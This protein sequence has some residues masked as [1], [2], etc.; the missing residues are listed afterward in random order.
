MSKTKTISPP[1]DLV[2]QE[3]ASLTKEVVDMKAKKVKQQDRQAQLALNQPVPVEELGKSD[4][5]QC[6][7]CGL[8]FKAAIVV[9]EGREVFG[10]K[11]CEI[12]ISLYESE[13]DQAR[14]AEADRVK[15]LEFAD[16][17]AKICPPL[18]AQPFDVTKA[19]EG[20]REEREMEWRRIARRSGKP[21]ETWRP[22]MEAE[23]HEAVAKVQAWPYS[24]K[25]LGLIGVSGHSKTR[26]MF[27][28]IKRL[29]REGRGC[30]YINMAVFGREVG[31]RFSESASAANSWINGLCK[32]PVLFL[33]DIGKE[34]MT[35]RV[36]T[37]LYG[38]LEIR[39]REMLPIY[40]TANFGGD[41]LIEKMTSLKRDDDES[42]KVSDR[43]IPIVRRLR[44]YS[45]GIVI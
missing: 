40:F 1:F 3:P 11:R 17:W 29:L 13:E 20:I 36:E 2:G 45:E 25:G 44:K 37:E 30:S 4:I 42:E 31:S 15:E 43:A 7:G 24:D 21:A 28:L 10:A 38:I 8:P 39:T 26:L 27:T 9:Y 23:I 18:Y 5:R 22:K 12:C 41:A 14:Q 33:D 35:E 32:I 19:I 34:K 6:I 16:R